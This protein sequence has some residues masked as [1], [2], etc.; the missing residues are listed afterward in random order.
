MQPSQHSVILEDNAG[1]AS[2]ELNDTNLQ[3][4]SEA[5]VLS[6]CQSEFGQTHMHE[7]VLECT[8]AAPIVLDELE[9]GEIGDCFEE[10]TSVSSGNVLHKLW[11]FL[12]NQFS[13]KEKQIL[14]FTHNAISNKEQDNSNENILAEGEKGNQ[15]NLLVA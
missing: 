12:N 11:P 7:R 1:A 2:D 15:F 14:E 3:T 5:C 6:S 4:S 9:P 10:D 8:K 13:E